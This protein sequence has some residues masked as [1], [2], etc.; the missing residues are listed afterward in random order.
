MK[1][2]ETRIISAAMHELARTIQCGDGIANAACA[3]AAE[4]LDEQTVEIRRLKDRLQKFDSDS[5]FFVTD[6]ANRLPGELLPE[7]QT[8]S[9]MLS[10][11]TQLK[12][13]RNNALCR[14]DEIEKLK[15]ANPKHNG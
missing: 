15:T 2:V 14:V 12:N 13:E 4:R 8:W 9:A 7:K 5:H 11:V 10:A 3:E 6:I 1:R